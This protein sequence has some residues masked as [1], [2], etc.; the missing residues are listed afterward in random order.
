MPNCL[1]VQ[2]VPPEPAF[3]IAEALVAAGVD[4]DIRRVFAGDRVP[5]D[6]S[7]FDGL[8]IMGGPM[9]AASDHGFPTRSAEIA[10]LTDA[11]GRKIP[12][13]GVCLGAQL[14]A[15]AGGGS[16]FPGP[17][18]P[19]VGWGPAEFVAECAD[20]QLLAGLPKTLTVMHWHGDTFDLPD[21]AARLAGNSNYP[22]QGF[23]L[24]PMAWGLQFHLEVTAAAVDGFLSAFASDAEQAGG[25]PEAIRAAT[26]A[27]LTSL[28]ESRDLVLGRFAALVADGVASQVD[29][30]ARQV[31]E[32]AGMVGGATGTVIGTDRVKLPAT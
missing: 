31:D 30:V 18:G 16:V 4:I 10:L 3:A 2:H 26:P 20:D 1:V 21:G 17:A 28:S 6:A 8:V 27:A 29:G 25:G 32:V 24:G 13:L 9:S 12:T 15:V 22:N 7:G 14:L 11:V 19:E 5:A 23:R